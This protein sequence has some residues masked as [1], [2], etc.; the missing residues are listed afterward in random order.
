MF[1]EIAPGVIVETGYRGANV[2][3][4]ITDEGT[5]C[6]DTPMIPSQAIEWR[7]KIE[8]LGGK[9]SCRYILITDM[10]RGHILGSQF[11]DCPVIGHDLAWKDMK[12][13]GDNYKHRVRQFFK[14]EPMIQAEFT[15]IQI[16]VP[17]ITFAD[18]MAISIGGKF[19]EFIHTGGHTVATSLVYLPK[20]KVLFTGDNVL[21]NE[22]PYMSQANT[23]QW[24]A[25]LA[26]IKRMDVEI[27]V[28]GHGPP[29][30]PEAVDETKRYIEYVRAEVYKLVQQG[31]GRKEVA[32]ILAPNLLSIYP[33]PVERRSRITQQIKQGVRKVFNETTHELKGKVEVREDE[34]DL[35]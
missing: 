19:V 24:L 27:V 13:Y 28:P 20:E 22:H 15:N 31:K 25:A 26:M 29:T 32:N 9:K 14:R 21:C 5:I 33:V 35:G 4:I 7:N 30:T 10:H 17:E 23:R 16:I 6:I 2:S 11:F 18:K 1:Y 8:E 3:A 34:E 12:G